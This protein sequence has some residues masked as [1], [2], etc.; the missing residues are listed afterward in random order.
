MLFFT[1]K[2]PHLKFPEFFFFAATL[3]WPPTLRL[4]HLAASQSAARIAQHFRGS[5]WKRGLARGRGGLRQRQGESGMRKNLFIWRKLA[6][7][8]PLS[9]YRS[10]GLFILICVKA[11]ARVRSHHQHKKEREEVMLWD[12][13]H[14]LWVN[15]KTRRTTDLFFLAVYSRQW[16]SNFAAA[17]ILRQAPLKSDSNSNAGYY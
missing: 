9:V 17:E 16:N 5:R 11:A 6:V 10:A 13:W 3:N 12:L 7:K 15:V 14:S 8:L 1:W 4:G 2:K